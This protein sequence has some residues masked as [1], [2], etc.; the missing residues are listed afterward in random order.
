MKQV[1]VSN[2]KARA[3]VQELTP[4][5]GS[6]TFAEYTAPQGNTLTHR[7]VVYSYGYHFPMFIAEWLDGQEPQW[8]E[9]ADKYSRST[10]KQ[11]GQ[12]H[13][14]A[15]TLCFSTEQMKRIAQSGMAG[16]AVLGGNR[17]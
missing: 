12:L 9:N 16:L 15:T 11:F 5:R 2:I 4:F 8:Y 3:K 13:P 6:N 7:Y 14:H 10:S 17:A 1:L